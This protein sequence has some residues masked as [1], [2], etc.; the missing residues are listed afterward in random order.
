[1][2]GRVRGGSVPPAAVV[3]GELEVGVERVNTGT[4]GTTDPVPVMMPEVVVRPVSA[5]VGVPDVVGCSTVMLTGPQPA[6]AYVSMAVTM[7]GKRD[8]S[9]TPFL[10]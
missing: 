10:P 3:D 9:F 1:M 6:S 4:D 8:H 5:G 7:S 2:N